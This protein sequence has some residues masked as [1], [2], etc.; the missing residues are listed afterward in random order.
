VSDNLL[1]TVVCLF[2]AVVAIFLYRE[3]MKFDHPGWRLRRAWR[4]AHF[5]AAALFTV[6][7]LFFANGGNPAN[8]PL[9]AIFFGSFLLLAVL[10]VAAGFILLLTTPKQ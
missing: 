1:Y 4:L 2:F 9:V 5:G 3:K 8:D 10:A 6:G 7:G